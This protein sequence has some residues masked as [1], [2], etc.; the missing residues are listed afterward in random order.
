MVVLTVVVVVVLVAPNLNAFK[1]LFL[2]R[3]EE[4]PKISHLTSRQPVGRCLSQA[5][6]QAGIETTACA[7]G[8]QL[9]DCGVAGFAKSIP[10]FA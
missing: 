8:R 4:S 3:V 7:I 2:S 9:K 5:C 1:K 10:G 6:R